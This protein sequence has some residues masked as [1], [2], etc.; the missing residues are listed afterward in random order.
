M[1]FDVMFPLELLWKITFSKLCTI[2]NQ[3]PSS[4][5]IP[6][7]WNVQFLPI[8][9][10]RLILWNVSLKMATTKRC[11]LFVTI[12]SLSIHLSLRAIYFSQYSTSFISIFNNI[13][14]IVYFF[15]N[16]SHFKYHVESYTTIYY[17]YSIHLMTF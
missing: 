11:W 5:F 14:K 3:M 4:V 9:S 16:F 6:S 12:Q 17:Y 10:M 13:I 8:F 15:L 2:F 1:W 7:G